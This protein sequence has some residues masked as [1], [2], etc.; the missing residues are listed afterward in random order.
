MGQNTLKAPM[1]KGNI[2]YVVMGNTI[3]TNNN[4]EQLRVM[5]EQ[6]VRFMVHEVH[7]KT[8]TAAQKPQGENYQP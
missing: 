8:N 1:I 5:N 4:H 3:T 2:Q 6:S 7:T